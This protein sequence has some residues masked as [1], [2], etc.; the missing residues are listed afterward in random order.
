MGVFDVEV[1]SPTFTVIL[2]WSSFI[3]LSSEY[4]SVGRVMPKSYFSRPYTLWYDFTNEW[5][6]TGFFL[7]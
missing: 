7:I 5:S 6:V 2:P 1:C 3:R 4:S